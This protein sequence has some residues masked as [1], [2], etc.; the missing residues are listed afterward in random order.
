MIH[1][2]VVK[3]LRICCQLSGCVKVLIVPMCLW[4]A[5]L[6]GYHFLAGSHLIELGD[7]IVVQGHREITL[8]LYHVDI[9]KQLLIRRVHIIVQLLLTG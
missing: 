1:P 2:A 6:W 9:W 8:V 4:V 3:H 7:F 5:Y